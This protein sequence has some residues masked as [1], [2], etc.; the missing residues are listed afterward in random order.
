MRK[1]MEILLQLLVELVIR[2]LEW[3][4]SQGWF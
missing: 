1:I 2:L 4:L 3:V